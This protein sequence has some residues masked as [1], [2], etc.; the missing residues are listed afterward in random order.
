[1]GKKLLHESVYPEGILVELNFLIACVGK[2]L[3]SMYRSK[4]GKKVDDLNFLLQR[5]VKTWTF[6]RNLNKTPSFSLDM[7]SKCTYSKLTLHLWNFGLHFVNCGQ[8]YVSY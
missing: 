3:K 1:M 5:K 4:K 2:F 8:I 6:H 7:K